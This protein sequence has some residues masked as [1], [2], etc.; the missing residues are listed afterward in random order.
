MSQSSDRCAGCYDDPELGHM[1]D[2]PT[3]I[4]DLEAEVERLRAALALIAS[5]HPDHLSP[6]HRD[7]VQ[8]ARAALAAGDGHVHKH[9]GSE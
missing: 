8:I 6:D 1:F 5:R 2:C 9:G 7:A 4:A 3:R